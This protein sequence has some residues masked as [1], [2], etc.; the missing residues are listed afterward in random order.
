MSLRLTYMSN[1]TWFRYDSVHNIGKQ[2]FR[3]KRIE[4]I[5]LLRLHIFSKIR[6]DHGKQLY[7]FCKVNKDHTV[8][9]YTAQQAEL[10]SSVGIVPDW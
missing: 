2:E 7:L 5:H 6:D 9:L 4:I 8:K 1:S 3:L 10:G